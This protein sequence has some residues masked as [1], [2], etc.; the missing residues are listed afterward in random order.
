MKIL[1]WYIIKKFLGSFLFVCLIFTMISVVIDYSEHVDD[2][3]KAGVNDTG[4]ILNYYL[5]FIPWINGI[6]WPLF[7]LMAVVFFTSRLAKN[8]EIISILSS[9]V[10]YWRL[11]LPYLV[12]GV[13]IAGLHYMGSHI[14]IPK[15]NKKFMTFQNSVLKP[16]NEKTLADNIHIFLDSTSKIYMRSYIK[17]DT[18][19]RGIFLEGFRD[20]KLVYLLKADQ[21]HW[22]EAPNHWEFRDYTIHTFDDGEESIKMG[23]NQRLDTVLNLTP[24]DFIRYSNQREMMTSKEIRDFIA[25]EK[26][27][28]ISAARKMHVELHRRNADPFTILVLV[29]IGFTVASRKVR[30]GM[31]LH[32][33]LGICIGAVYILLSRFSITFAE[34]LDLPTGISIWLP[35]IFFTLVAFY[36]LSKAQK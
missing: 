21:L 7:A 24:Q 1:D 9:G 5:N 35:N 19:A 29:I 18:S 32:L 25:Y 3:L 14:V 34:K 8:S 6:L 27:K 20:D 30:G 26:A 16:N 15:G 2:F 17:E 23:K 13:F 12:T 10:S 33:A 22:V 4:V 36:M 31:G 28:G 11:L